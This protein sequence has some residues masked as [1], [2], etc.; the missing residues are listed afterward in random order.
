MKTIFFKF[1]FLLA[2]LGILNFANAQKIGVVDTDYILNKLPQYK[3][4]ETRL[5][6]ELQLGNRIFKIYNLNTNEKNLLLKMKKYF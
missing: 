6:A 1:A 2:F 4:A 3:E 5:N